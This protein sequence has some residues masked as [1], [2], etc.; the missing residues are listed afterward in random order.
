[1]QERTEIRIRQA[2]DFDETDSAVDYSEGRSGSPFFLVPFS[3]IGPD[4]RSKFR[5]SSVVLGLFELASCGQSQGLSTVNGF[6]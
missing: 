3:R 1:M 4:R 5:L 6:L 2:I